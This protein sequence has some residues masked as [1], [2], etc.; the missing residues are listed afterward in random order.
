MIIDL[1]PDQQGVIDL[2][3]GSGAFQNPSGV[4]DPRLEIIREQ[5][6]HESLDDGTTRCHC[7]PLL[8]KAGRRLSAVN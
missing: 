4:L 5:L 6:D 8:T 7:C 1:K 3:V 2:A